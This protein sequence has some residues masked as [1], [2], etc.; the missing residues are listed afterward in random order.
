M[1]RA[2]LAGLF[3]LGGC[4]TSSVS[5]EEWHEGTRQCAEQCIEFWPRG[6]IMRS[7]LAKQHP[8]LIENVLSNEVICATAGVDSDEDRIIVFEDESGLRHTYSSYARLYAMARVCDAWPSCEQHVEELVDLFCFAKKTVA[9]FA[10]SRPWVVIRRS[11]SDARRLAVRIGEFHSSGDHRL[12][13]PWFGFTNVVFSCG[14]DGRLDL[15][16]ST[17]EESGSDPALLF[18]LCDQMAVALAEEFC[19]RERVVKSEK[20]KVVITGEGA[21]ACYRVSAVYDERS[22]QTLLYMRVGR[23]KSIGALGLIGE[24]SDAAL[25]RAALERGGSRLRPAAAREPQGQTLV[26]RSQ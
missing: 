10:T 13:P 11:E 15:M 5:I 3:V 7:W 6:S 4:A 8:K 20:G 9:A 24:A 18:A 25:V 23:A 1:G 26:I 12:E 16:F 19:T 21:G 22:N 2:V 17:R 14:S